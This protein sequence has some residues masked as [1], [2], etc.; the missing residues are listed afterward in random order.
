MRNS[1]GCF[2]RSVQPGT[3][4]LEKQPRILCSFNEIGK[5]QK[6][7]KR[8][9]EKIKT[10][11]HIVSCSSP[12]N[13]TQQLPATWTQ[14]ESFERETHVYFT[15]RATSCS[16]FLP[17]YSKTHESCQKHGRSSKHANA[18]KHVVQKLKMRKKTDSSNTGTIFYSPFLPGRAQQPGKM[19]KSPETI[20]VSTTG[21][22]S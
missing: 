13:K 2:S 22:S 15:R 16:Q 4:H 1:M 7:E 19:Y 20:I 3:W 11:L 10:E 8:E 12:F 21:H 18:K 5:A 14:P 17:G 9:K 6:K